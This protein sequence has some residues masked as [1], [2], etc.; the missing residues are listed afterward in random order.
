MIVQTK[1]LPWAGIREATSNAALMDML[2]VSRGQARIATFEVPGSPVVLEFVELA[3]ADRRTV[4]GAVQDPGSTRMQLQVRDLN[5]AIQA[6]V[7]AGGGVISTEGKPVEL[8]AGRG[9]SI[10]AAMVRDPDN[11]FLVL[12]EAAAPRP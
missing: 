11:L 2:G 6:V 7:R 8:P 3:G 12:I 10:R 5:A 9:G 4:R 1:A